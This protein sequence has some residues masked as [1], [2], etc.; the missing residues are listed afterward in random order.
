MHFNS[1]RDT[2]PLLLHNKVLTIHVYVLLA[3]MYLLEHRIKWKRETTIEYTH[4]K[5]QP[6]QDS[7]IKSFKDENR[8]LECRYSE[9]A[10][11]RGRQNIYLNFG[12]M[13]YINLENIPETEI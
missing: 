2:L 6:T 8:W 4:C 7:R 3:I 9:N 12:N 13:Y 5:M 1:Q 10:G 11:S